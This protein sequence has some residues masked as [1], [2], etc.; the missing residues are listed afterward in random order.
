[1][2][3]EAKYIDYSPA[4]H[5]SKHEDGAP[6][7]N[8]YSTVLTR[9]HDSPAAQAMLYAAGVPDQNAM[10]K[11]PQIGVASV[12]WEGN[13]CNMH[14][15][16]LGKTVKKAITDRGS[17]AWQYNTVGVSDGITMGTEGMRFSLQ[18]RELIADSVETVTCAQYHD[19]NIC[20][21][22]CDKNM[23]GVIMG[24]AR[25]NRPSIMIYGGTIAVGYSDILR[26][27][28]N[29]SSC[30]E[31]AGAYAYDTLRQP[32]DGGDTSKNK[33]EIIE[34]L[35]RHACPGA[36]ACGG[37]FTANTMATAIE[38]MGLSLPGSSSTPAESPAKMR[39][40]VKVA[41]AI[42]V[43]I[44]K[45]ITPRKLL[46]KRSFEN[47]LVMTMALGGSTNA[48]LHFLAMARTAEVDL[49]LDDFQ[50][51]SDK[52]PFIADLAPSGK[53]YMADL[54]E[55]GGIPSVQKLL[56]AA[57]LLDGDIPTVTGK[58]LAQNVESFPSLAQDQV[59]IR[60]LDNPI[61]P[62]GHIQILRG[63]L[64]PG[65][66]VA[67][68]TGK[69]GLKFTGRARVFN[70]EHELN[71]ALAKS[72]IPR[73]ENLVLIVR[74]EGPK[75]GPGMP[76]QLKA[77]AALMGAKLTNV[78]LLTDG[79]YSGASHGFIVGHIVPEAA[80]GG[81]IA[82]VQDGDVITIDA[83]TNEL[84]MDVSKE[85]LERRS[86]IWQPPKP[87]VTRGVM[88]KYARLP[89]LEVHVSY[90]AAQRYFDIEAGL[91]LHP[92]EIA[93]M[94]SIGEKVRDAYFN[95]VINIGDEQ[96]YCSTEV[97][98]T[99]GPMKASQTRFRAGFAAMGGHRAQP[100]IILRQFARA[101]MYDRRYGACYGLPG[102]A[103]APRKRSKT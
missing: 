6:V 91:A 84:K 82:L 10:K 11:S 71:D 96:R 100:I 13:P 15:L 32:D 27:R 31:A 89:H 34:D 81:P 29:I 39:E 26:K 63:N 68:I 70:K 14:L 9:G 17:I 78:A 42:H 37:M 41:D 51:V 80:V 76:E 99:Q 38:S 5:G 94:P 16:D 87:Q 86:K 22:G 88:A 28:I 46:T 101:S 53:H 102:P 65:G 24:M 57:G 43:C 25:H 48:V 45:D 72:Q 7:L 103:R 77:S 95:D 50:R 85:E 62:T 66:A 47:A 12:W 75:G 97:I 36:G 79:R 59:I 98:I 1:M 52:I 44:E 61:K 40:C 74:Y 2:P 83:E 4:P 64:A 93:A 49:T 33:D 20:I 56:I 60:P 67:K 58:T 21:P 18:T 73:D 35:E 55:V 30:F 69:E 54:Y 3:E 90:E 92:N 19:A 23:P 8:R